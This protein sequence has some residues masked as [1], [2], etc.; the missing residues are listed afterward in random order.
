MLNENIVDKMVS[1]L[2]E[3]SMPIQW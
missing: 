1:F 3:L 2:G